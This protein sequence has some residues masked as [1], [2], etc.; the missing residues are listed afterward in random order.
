MP[1]VPACTFLICGSP[2]FPE[3]FELRISN[4][5]SQAFN[6]KT[7]VVSDSEG[8]THA[9]DEHDATQTILI[10]TTDEGAEGF[11]FGI[12]P[13][14][15]ESVFAPAL[16]EEDPF[17]R[18][19]LWQRLKQWQ[20]IHRNLTDQQIGVVDMALWDLAGRRFNTPVYKLLGGFRDKGNPGGKGRT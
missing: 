12:N 16:L 7:S 19:K 17:D 20:R 14:L 2:N 9:G 4:I 18:E 8:H 3:E 15:V 1:I 11:A 5:K 13:S 6:Y 10:I